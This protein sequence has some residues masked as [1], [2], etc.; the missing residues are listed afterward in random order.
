MQTEA[1]PERRGNLVLSL[2]PG[3]RIVLA[4]GEVVITYV[5]LRDRGRIRLGI[6]APVSIRIDRGKI[7][8]ERMDERREAERREQ[9]GAT[10]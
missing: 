10:E 3:E 8:D 5:E 6:Q 7:H 9:Q 1:Q 4:E 2:D